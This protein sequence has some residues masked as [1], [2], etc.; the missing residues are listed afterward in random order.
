MLDKIRRIL[1]LVKKLLNPSNFGLAPIAYA[2]FREQGLR[3]TIRKVVSVLGITG[4]EAQ[5][6]N[7]DRWHYNSREQFDL[8]GR[9]EHLFLNKSVLIVGA[10]GLPQCKKYRVIQKIEQLT[11]V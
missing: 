8:S 10:L 4:S 3:A 9:G 5:I 11:N 6:L 1:Q 2:Y 7:A